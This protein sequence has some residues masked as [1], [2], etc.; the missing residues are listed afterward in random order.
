M[1]IELCPAPVLHALAKFTDPKDLRPRCQGVWV[2]NS[3]R[4]LLLIATDGAALAVLRVGDR[5]PC[6]SFTRLLPT[7]ALARLPKARAPRVQLVLGPERD[8]LDHGGDTVALPAEIKYLDAVDWRRIVPAEVSYEPGQ[9]SPPLLALFSNLA[10]ALG[11]KDGRIRLSQNGESPARVHIVGH[12]DFIGVA[13]PMRP[14]FVAL[15]DEQPFNPTWMLP[16]AP[17]EE[18][19]T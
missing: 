2:E 18:S 5:A 8:V 13:S 1:E 7:D 9:F 3:A 11:F 14:E 10:K 17:V 15:P 4:G 16:D 6:E 19:L 12:A